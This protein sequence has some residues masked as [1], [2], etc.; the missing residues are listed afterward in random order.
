MS[1]KK[2]LVFHSKLGAN[3]PADELDVLDEAKFFKEGLI[4]LDMMFISRILKMTLIKI[5]KLLK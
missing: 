1:V 5:L 2:A 4:N 3:P